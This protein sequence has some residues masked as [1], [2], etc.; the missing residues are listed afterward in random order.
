MQ[1]LNYYQLFLSLTAVH[2]SEQHP[3][4]PGSA[5]EDVRVDGREAGECL[6]RGFSQ[7]QKQCVFSVHFSSLHAL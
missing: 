6:S 5:G 7:K 2:P 1:M 4:A 3:A